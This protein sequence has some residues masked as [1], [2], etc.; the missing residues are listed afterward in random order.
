M[1]DERQKGANLV[2]WPPVTVVEGIST[3]AHFG[4]LVP[5]VMHHHNI[6]LEVLEDLG[7][8]DKTII[9]VLNKMDAVD[10]DSLEALN[11]F[12]FPNAVKISTYTGLGVEELKETIIQTLKGLNSSIN[13]MLP[14][15]RW[16]IHAMLK[17][18]G[19]ITTE[20][21]LDSGIKIEA[22]VSD[23]IKNQLKEYLVD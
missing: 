6:T 19:S 11:L 17:R 4:T 22:L 14:L 7:I 15:D 16:D 12:K 10:T 2:A 3:A 1:K 23:R 20:K 8:K 13:L 9:T 21:Y 5:N 18:E